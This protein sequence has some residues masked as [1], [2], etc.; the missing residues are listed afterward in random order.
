MNIF[1][2]D[3]FNLRKGLFTWMIIVGFTLIFFM[4]FYPSMNTPAMQEAY[5]LEM[6]AMP[7]EILDMLG[8]DQMPDFTNIM[9]YFAYTM[10]YIALAGGIYAALL[11]SNSLIREESNGTIEFL[12]AQP[13]TRTQVVF[14]KMCSAACAFLLYFASIVI[15]SLFMILLLRPSGTDPAVL[16]GDTLQIV[17]G[18]AFSGLVFMAIGFLLSS[19]MKSAQQATPAAI[20][21]VFGTYIMGMFA[22]AFEE[23]IQGIGTL[24]YLSPLDYAVPSQIY[25]VGFE[26]PYIVIGCILIILT[27]SATF[28]I[29]R[30]KDLM[31]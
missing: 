24:V 17:A 27:S 20:G 26:L 1:R 11:G 22:K 9:E 14:F 16:I 31:S 8:M 18:M 30:K 12:Y 5:K 4:V 10:Q 25:S 3:F 15:S 13:I 23:N 6:A 21:V 29:Y 28:L 2:L 7:K 19:V